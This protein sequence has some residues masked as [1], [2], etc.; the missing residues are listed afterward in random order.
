MRERGHTH[1][2]LCVFVFNSVRRTYKSQCYTLG[3]DERIPVLITPIITVFP[4]QP[5]PFVAVCVC[6]LS[7][8]DGSNIKTSMTKYFLNQ[9]TERF[10]G[11]LQLCQAAG[12]AGQI[13]IE[14]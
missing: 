12:V 11:I 7:G 2:S 10:A 3:Y 13:I 5:P 4:P 6:P 1:C 9:R 8:L 14:Y